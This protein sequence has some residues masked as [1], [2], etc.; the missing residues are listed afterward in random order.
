MNKMDILAVY[1][2]C[3]NCAACPLSDTRTNTVFGVGALDADIMFVGEGPG[4]NE[5]L[6]GEPFVGR[7]GKLLDHFLGAVGMDRRKNVYICNI[8]KCRPP[9][10]RDPKPEEEDAC[11]PFLRKQI[12]IIEPKI[13]VCLGRIAACRLIDP[14][15]KV[16]RQHGQFISKG[17]FLMT[18]TFH[19]AAILRNPNNRG[20]C[21]RDFFAIEAKAKEIGCK[22]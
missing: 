13:I 9:Q 12:K 7:A 22:L 11:M 5:D 10:N 6:T 20:D 14:D 3:K 15:Y 18:A 16:T 1:E 2:D 4:E 17:S 8:V 21:M 19:P